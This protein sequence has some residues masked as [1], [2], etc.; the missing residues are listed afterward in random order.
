M[1]FLEFFHELVFRFLML[2]IRHDAIYRADCDAL[3]F[4]MESDTLGAKIGIYDE[5]VLPFGY[6]SV[7]TF[8]L[9]C[10]AVDAFFVN[11]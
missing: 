2:R 11:E 6:C 1:E 5:N 4:V 7:R 10:R 9:A 8:G 3:R